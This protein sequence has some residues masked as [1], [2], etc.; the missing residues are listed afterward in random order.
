MS[1]PLRVRFY[2]A[3][4]GGSDAWQLNIAGSSA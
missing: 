2:L 3:C 4:N 1:P